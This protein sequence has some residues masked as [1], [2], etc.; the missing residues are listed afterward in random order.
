MCDV[1][2]QDAL[3]HD[4]QAYGPYCWRID[5]VIALK[6]PYRI[7]GRLG[8]WPAPHNLPIPPE[9]LEGTIGLPSPL[10]LSAEQ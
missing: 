6:E 1:V 5:K 2:P 9:V 10:P 8:L 4:P 3:Q 7:H